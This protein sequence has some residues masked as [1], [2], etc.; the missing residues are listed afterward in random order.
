MPAPLATAEDVIIGKLR[1][2]R[3][4]G[5]ERQL[6]DVAGILAT[7]DPQLDHA[8]LERWLGELGLEDEW[9]RAEALAR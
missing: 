5:S 3:E 9:R 1:W 2:A 4:G 7:N 8:Y 6:A